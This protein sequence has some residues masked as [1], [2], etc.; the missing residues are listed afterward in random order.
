MSRELYVKAKPLTNF[1][2]LK[3]VSTSADPRKKTAY[4]NFCLEKSRVA[5]AGVE[6]L[7]NQSSTLRIIVL[8]FIT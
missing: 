2:L 4:I 5:I 8:C 3:G 6:G 1:E 7:G